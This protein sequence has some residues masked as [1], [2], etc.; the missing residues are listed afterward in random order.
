MNFCK[1]AAVSFF[2]GEARWDI[3]ADDVEREFDAN[4]A[5]AE[6]EDV[7]VVVFA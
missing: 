1:P 6:N 4:H 7:A 3:R 2:T 5:R